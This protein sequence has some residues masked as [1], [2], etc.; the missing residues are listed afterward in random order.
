MG[1]SLLAVITV[2][3]GILGAT[4]VEFP[5]STSPG[6]QLYPDVCWDGSAFWVVW[7]DDSLGTVRGVRV[8]ENGEFLTDE[9]ELL[10][11]GEDPGPVGYPCVAAGPD[12]IAVEA[13]VMAG[14]NEFMTE[15]W[16]VIHQEFTFEGEPLLSEPIR[17]P[18]SYNLEDR[19]SIPIVL[20]GKEHFF[21]FFKAGLETPADVHMASYAVGINSEE[22]EPVLA[23][24]SSFLA[25]ELEPPVACW[26]EDSFMVL[27]LETMD[28]ETKGLFLLDTL[29]YAGTGY[30][31]GLP[32]NGFS[33]VE[34]NKTPKYQALTWNGAC[35]LLVSEYYSFQPPIEHQIA[36]DILDSAGVPVKDSTTVV[37]N[38][39]EIMCYYP[40][41]VFGEE[42]YVAVWENRFKKDNTSHLYAIEVDTG[43]QIL[44]SGY[45]VWKGLVDRFPANAFGRDKYLLVWSDNREGE[46]N[47][48][49]MLFDTLE[50]FEGVSEEPQPEQI[51]LQI[52]VSPNP[53]SKRTT[54]SLT[55][56]LE[57][58]KEITLVIYDNTGSLIRRLALP[59]GEKAVVW[60]G[61]DEMGRPI[62][63]GVYF[64]KPEGVKARAA[65]MVIVR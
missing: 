52:S 16:G 23:W 4:S 40:D 46:F 41:A 15:L 44:K 11:S 26:N 1:R 60:N 48:Y 5:I 38:G 20:F 19:V 32:R 28:W 17:F 36:F 14:Y 6:D 58:D 3:G 65:K 54:I 13:R 9:V 2:V 55:R 50:V 35:Y 63:S 24:Q 18:E 47:V 42:T 29:A 62:R 49:G 8:S 56:G 22:E 59:K 27:F 57:M 39:T 30:S 51:T 33:A 34:E 21:S 45:V 25:L 61:N 53:F 7:Q 64:V 12:R 37:D 31:F 10:E 43:G